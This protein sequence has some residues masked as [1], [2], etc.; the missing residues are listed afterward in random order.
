MGS[1]FKYLITI[2]SITILYGVYYWGI[3]AVI[4]LPERVDYIEASVLKQSGYKIDIVNPDL[5]MGLIPSVWLKADR[6][7]ILNND[8]S[9][10]LSIEKPCINI[11]LLPLILKDVDIKHFSANDISANFVF[12]KDK[13][14]K[15]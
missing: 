15:R 8:N 9:K 3:P 5:K 13:K 10:A 11:R 7:D 6:L 1:N 14:F 2:F 4:N 12:D